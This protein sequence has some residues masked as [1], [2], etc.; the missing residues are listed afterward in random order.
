MEIIAATVQTDWPCDALVISVFGDEARVLQAIQKGAKGYIL[1]NSGLETIVDDIQA[2]LDGGSP[3]SPQ[4]A[5]HLLSNVITP[6]RS[7]E[8]ESDLTEREREILQNV[9]RGYKRSE[10]AEQLGISI[11]TVGNHIHNIYRKLD[12]GSNIEAVSRAARMGLI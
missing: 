2:V 5:R 10:I 9:A 1:K 6:V 8:T 4:I 11:S 3:I 12:V 7:N